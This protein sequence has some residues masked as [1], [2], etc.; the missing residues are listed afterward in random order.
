MPI[1]SKMGFLLIASK[2]SSP[3]F[4]CGPRRSVRLRW[5]VTDSRTEA[6][7]SDNLSTSLFG[8]SDWKRPR[9]F[10]EKSKVSLSF[11]GELIEKI[12][13]PERLTSCR[14]KELHSWLNGQAIVPVGT[15]TI[16]ELVVKIS[17]DMP[18]PDLE[19]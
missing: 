18:R 5:T 2:T 10:N 1:F 13:V 14:S 19:A 16:V 12:A 17:P 6:R 7:I 9:E 4:S 15:S 11:S 8:S 3:R